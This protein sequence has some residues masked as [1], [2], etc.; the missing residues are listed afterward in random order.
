MVNT[1]ALFSRCGKN[2]KGNTKSQKQKPWASP[3]LARM[4]KNGVFLIVLCF[5]SEFVPSRENCN[6]PPGMGGVSA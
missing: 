6:I 5:L 4:G 1:P 3:G 2:W